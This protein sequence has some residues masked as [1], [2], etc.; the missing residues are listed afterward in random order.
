MLFDFN[1]EK[2][3]SQEAA[4]KIPKFIG[5][6]KTCKACLRTVYYLLTT[7]KGGGSYETKTLPLAAGPAGVPDGLGL[8]ACGGSPAEPA[9]TDQ[10]AYT[11]AEDSAQE[12]RS[13]PQ[14]DGGDAGEEADEAESASETAVEPA[15]TGDALDEDGYY[16]T[17][18][19]VA[20]YIHLYGHLPDNFLT[21]KEAQDL[22]WSGGS[23]EPYAP[24]CSIGGSRFGN[25]EGLLPDKKGRTWTE[26]DIDTMGAKSRGAKRIVFS[27]DGLIYYTGDHY[28]SFELLYGEE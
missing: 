17:K 27:N 7:E 13:S 15:D 4:G 9:E 10:T 1:I 26:C 19:D 21:K 2:V 20:L 11:E 22:G 8:A 24:G 28:E 3:K 25:Y 12:D 23:L 16:T 14:E 18:E 6:N 5:M